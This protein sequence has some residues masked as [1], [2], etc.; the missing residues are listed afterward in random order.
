MTRLLGSHAV[1]GEEP[2]AAGRRPPGHSRFGIFGTA[3]GKHQET[4]GFPRSGYRRSPATCIAAGRTADKSGAKGLLPQLEAPDLLSL[5]APRRR[6]ARG[7]A[8]RYMR[9]V[10]PGL[11]ALVGKHGFRERRTSLRQG[12]TP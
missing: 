12:Q 11:L 1:R 2:V 7:T 6:A 10:P 3:S 9:S 5:S 4:R 8:L